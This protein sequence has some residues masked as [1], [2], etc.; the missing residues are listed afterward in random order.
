MDRPSSGH[1]SVTRSG[2]WQRSK[3]SF[4]LSRSTRSGSR[5]ASP[6][7]GPIRMFEGATAEGH[8]ESVVEVPPGRTGRI[9][10]LVRARFDSS[11]AAF[12]SEHRALS[13]RRRGLG[14]ED[15]RGFARRT[16]PRSARLKWMWRHSLPKPRK[17]ECRPPRKKGV[18]VGRRCAGSYR[19]RSY[20]DRARE[21][22]PG[23]VGLNN[24][25]RSGWRPERA[26]PFGRHISGAHGRRS[27]SFAGVST[28]GL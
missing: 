14:R 22:S 1:S 18:R 15:R 13:L 3:E 2:A 25:A 12:D 4:V 28:S 10:L 24:P 26:A 9:G 5:Q 21:S 19:V 23:E 7:R 17:K 16:P 11:I 8:D 20:P 6:R 27:S